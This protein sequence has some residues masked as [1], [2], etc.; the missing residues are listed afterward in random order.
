MMGFFVA[1]TYVRFFNDIVFVALPWG[2]F[3]GLA[4]QGKDIVYRFIIRYNS[5]RDFGP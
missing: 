1:L 2:S 4:Y 3:I 5:L